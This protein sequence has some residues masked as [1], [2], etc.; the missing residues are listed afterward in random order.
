ML[1]L[2]F[3]NFALAQDLDRSVAEN[4]AQNVASEATV[5]WHTDYGQAAAKALAGKKDLFIHFRTTTGLRG[6]RPRRSA[7]AAGPLR[8]PAASP[9]HTSTRGSD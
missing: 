2:L 6:A 4:V 1:T 8:L 7:A 9:R 5:A 3:L